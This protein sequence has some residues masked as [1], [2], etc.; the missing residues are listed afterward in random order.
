MSFPS[1]LSERVLISAFG[2]HTQD[3]SEYCD[4]RLAICL[5]CRHWK[6]LI[7]NAPSAWN[8]LPISLYTSSRYIHFCVEKSKKADLFLLFVL[9]RLVTLESHVRSL[10]IMSTRTPA[11]VVDSSFP[12]FVDDQPRIREVCIHCP[13]SPSFSRIKFWLSELDTRILRSVTLALGHH[14]DDDSDRTGAMILGNPGAPV[15]LSELRLGSF[16]P[17]EGLEGLCRNLVVLRL[18]CMGRRSGVRWSTF[19]RVLCLASNLKLLQLFDVECVDVAPSVDAPV[20][21]KLTDLI[22]SYNHPSS[23]EVVSN[24]RMPLLT[25]LRLDIRSPLGRSQR[26]TVDNFVDLCGGLLGQ[27]TTLDIGS[28]ELSFEEGDALFS[29]MTKIRVLDLWRASGSMKAAFLH[30]LRRTDNCL[31]GLSK[32]RFGVPLKDA[33]LQRILR[34]SRAQLSPN[35]TIISPT[36]LFLKSGFTQQQSAMID[37]RVISSPVTH[38]VT[39]GNW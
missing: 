5:V 36:K 25:G 21:G 27:L 34:R 31:S 32:V 18:T 1:E 7:Y 29:A 20:L 24:I 11:A 8:H 3:F 13:Y 26:P 33:E 4:N 17:R 35:C 9:I 12:I 16:I 6:I 23:A 14:P 30:F 28:M 37:S 22:L 2:C 38:N 19:C 39:F 15:F 10:G